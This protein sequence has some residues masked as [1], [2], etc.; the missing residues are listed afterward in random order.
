MK[1]DWIKIIT[2]NLKSGEVLTQDTPQHQYR[3]K[4]K[5]SGEYLS[6]QA[7][8]DNSTNI[9]EYKL[10]YS[11]PDLRWE[12]F[13]Y[14]QDF[15]RIKHVQSGKYIEAVENNKTEL[16][17]KTKI[18]SQLWKEI[19]Q[20]DG[21]CKLVNKATGK[22]LTIERSKNRNVELLYTSDYSDKYDANYDKQGF[23]LAPVYE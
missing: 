2:P 21:W 16:S 11:Q 13:P 10:G 5:W 6:I 8:Q 23:L 4:S 7:G 1:M 19:R 9:T 3:I 18:D 12:I 20:K 22:A 15:I 14:E 17:E